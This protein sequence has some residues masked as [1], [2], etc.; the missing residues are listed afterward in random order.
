[1]DPHNPLI[2][3]NHAPEREHEKPVTLAQCLGGIA[4]AFV[5]GWF[6]HTFVGPALDAL[7]SFI[8]G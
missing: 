2:P 7:G 8:G 3:H 1:M 6:L 4:F 5:L